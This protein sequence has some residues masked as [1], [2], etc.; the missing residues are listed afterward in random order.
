[1]G[2]TLF[3]LEWRET[4]WQPVIAGLVA[5]RWLVS[6]VELSRSMVAERSRSTRNPLFF[7][8]RQLKL[9]AIHINKSVETDYP[10]W[11]KQSV[12]T[13]LFVSIAVGF[14]QRYNTIP[15]L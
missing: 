2:S 13:D 12:S 11:R 1:M 6:V 10:D 9:T 14:N 7:R 4:Q 8:N 3:P 5:E 15:F